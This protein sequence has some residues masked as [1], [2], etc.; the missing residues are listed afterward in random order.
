MTAHELARWLLEGPD[1]P[2]VAA[3]GEME[4][5]EEVSDIQPIP[6]E[7]G[8]RNYWYGGGQSH[9]SPALELI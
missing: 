9:E 1:L 3:H 4:D 5:L 7:G 8:W 2:V 6:R